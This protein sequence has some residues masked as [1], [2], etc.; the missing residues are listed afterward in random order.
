MQK[1]QSGVNFAIRAP[2][3]AT[4]VCCPM[5][6]SQAINFLV[7]GLGMIAGPAVWPQYFEA[8]HMRSA[9]WLLFMGGL[10]AVAASWVL[11]LE[12]IVLFRRLATWEPFDL[13]LELPDVRWAVSPS[14]YAIM[15]D[16][17]D[18]VVVAFRLQEQLQLKRAV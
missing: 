14:L 2:I 4:T 10:Q 13:S 16:T 5:T 6:P 15:E 9:I 7:V 17:D 8:E 11:G 18:H 1:S 12:G 3:G